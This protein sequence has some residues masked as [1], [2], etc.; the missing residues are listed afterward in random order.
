MTNRTQLFSMALPV[1]LLAG[2]G[3]SQA[4]R[5]KKDAEAEKSGQAPASGHS[6]HGEIVN[7]GTRQKAY[8]IGGTG[9]VRFPV[10][11]KHTDVQKFIE[12]GIGQLHGFWYFEAER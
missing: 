2:L 4:A 1:V 8:L 12:Q 9:R 10:T 6:Q 5:N 3:L 7:E 11:A